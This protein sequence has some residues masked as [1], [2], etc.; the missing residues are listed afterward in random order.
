MKYNWPSV[1]LEEV[2]DL[3]VGFVGTMAK[4]YT[5]DGVTFL[6][7]TNIEPFGITL[8]DIKFISPEFNEKLSK[9]Q[10]RG[11]DV[12][13]VRTGKPGACTVIPDIHGS[14]NCSDLVIV[15][16]NT[17]KIDP[18]FLAAYIN[19]ASGTIN[20]QLVGA[21]QQH[22]NVASAK[23]L[24]I[25]VPSIDVQKKI[26]ALIRNLN[27]KITLNRKINDNLAA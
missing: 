21:V 2:A 4:H 9:S 19:L 25:P 11:G 14:W 15:R 5:P 20:N 6:R 10:L 24:E 3:T 1:K 23:K 13:I 22:F 8:D 7:S 26:S 16:P 12:V 17:E 18:L 27:D